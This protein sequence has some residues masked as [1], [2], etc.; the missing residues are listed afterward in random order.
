NR[1]SDIGNALQIV[2]DK[3]KSFIP[4]QIDIFLTNPRP[5]VSI[6]NWAIS[7]NANKPETNEQIFVQDTRLI[8]DRMLLEGEPYFVSNIRNAAPEQRALV[9][10][11]PNSDGNFIAQASVP[12][13]VSGRLIGR[14]IVS[15]NRPY[16]FGRAE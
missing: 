12:M 10:H 3:V 2:R 9:S 16:E 4:T 7:W 5:E 6:S 11:L 13:A 1:A 15:F 14:L 8:D